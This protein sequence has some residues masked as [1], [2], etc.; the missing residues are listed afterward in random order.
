MSTI[1]QHIYHPTWSKINISKEFY[2]YCEKYNGQKVLNRFGWP[3]LLV[4]ADPATKENKDFCFLE[5]REKD[6]IPHEKYSIQE[7]IKLRWI[8]LL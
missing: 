2:D 6:I 7:M 3:G 5:L 1:N 4:D 8:I